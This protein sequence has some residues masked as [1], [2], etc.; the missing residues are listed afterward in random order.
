MNLSVRQAYLQAMKSFR[1]LSEGLCLMATHLKGSQYTLC[2]EMRGA[3]LPRVF[4]KVEF[5][6]SWC[7]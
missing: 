5:M 3:R 6:M 1:M 7:V 2:I 4:G